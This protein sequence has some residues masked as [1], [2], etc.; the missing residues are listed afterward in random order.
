MSN[1]SLVD[2]LS[3]SWPALSAR[4]WLLLLVPVAVLLLWAWRVRQRR[5]TRRNALRVW[6]PGRAK[7][8]L[9]IAPEAS[10]VDPLETPAW[11]A[12]ATRHQSAGTPR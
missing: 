10:A 5:R 11:L 7:R 6:N 9:A 2:L 4:G 1:T 8:M 3:L 12:N